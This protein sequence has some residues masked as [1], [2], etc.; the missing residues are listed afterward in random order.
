MRGS[1]P[2]PGPGFH[3]RDA[4]CLAN[5]GYHDQDAALTAFSDVVREESGQASVRVPGR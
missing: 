4:T 3:E 2:L 5:A 1:E